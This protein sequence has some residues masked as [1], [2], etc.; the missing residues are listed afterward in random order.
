MGR[1]TARVDFVLIMITIA[2]GASQGELIGLGLGL[3]LWIGLRGL[4]SVL[5]SGYH[6]EG[7]GLDSDSQA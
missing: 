2:I 4:R 5:R 6:W 1:G 7:S 3:G